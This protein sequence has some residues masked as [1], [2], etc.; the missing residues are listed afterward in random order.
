MERRTIIKGAAWS[1]P[2]IAA[3][4]AVP[5]SVASTKEIGNPIV[6]CKRIQAQ[7]QPHYS[8]VY[9]DGTVVI[10]NQGEVDSDKELQAACR[11]KGPL[12]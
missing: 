6:E 3:A 9:A 12:S 2:V 5:Q 11:N 8:V 1:L 7:G 4:I 10:K